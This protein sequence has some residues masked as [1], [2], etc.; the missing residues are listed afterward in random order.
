MNRA[1]T[2]LLTPNQREQ[3]L[4]TSLEE[5]VYLYGATYDSY[6][7]VEPGREVFWSADRR[8]FL[9]YARDGRYLHISGGLVAPDDVKETL[10]DEFLAWSGK[11]QCRL[12]FFNIVSEDVPYFAGRG[13]EITRWGDDQIVSLPNATWKGKAFEW[14][15]RQTNYATRHGL[16]L[17]EC[18]PEWMPRD[19]WTVLEREL[20]QINASALSRR[21]QVREI[22]FLNGTLDLEHLARRRLF[23]A[24]SLETGRIDGFVICNPCRGGAEWAIDLCQQRRDAVRGTI[25]FLI[26]QI[27]Q[28]LQMEGVDRASL[29]V[30]PAFQLGPALP[31]ESR[32]VRA[33]L[34]A[35]CYFRFIFDT[36]GMAQ[37][38]SRFRPGSE[39]RYLCAHPRVTVGSMASFIGVCGALRLSPRK[40]LRAL[41]RRS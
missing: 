10:L 11:Q 3:P 40:I 24:R 37:F 27:L 21:L 7:A 9:S 29:C 5:L 2:P 20:C 13:F 17:E 39:P 4:E 15:R 22:G 32:L 31:G 28:R 34:A 19:A 30:V 12:M 35:S 41:W 8:G 36:V 16:A 18:S 25:P 14:V 38:K 26:H 23:V 6:L 33:I 1:S